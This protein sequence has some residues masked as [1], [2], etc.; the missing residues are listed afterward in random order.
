MIRG[1]LALRA[2]PLN[3]FRAV[4]LFL[5]VVVGTFVLSLVLGLLVELTSSESDHT[6]HGHTTAGVR[7]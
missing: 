5:L 3:G 6:K 2:V 1:L 4:R 7:K